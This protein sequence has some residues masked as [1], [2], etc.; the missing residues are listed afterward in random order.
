MGCGQ[1]WESTSFG[2]KSLRVH[3]DKRI[4]RGSMK[5]YKVIKET[6]GEKIA[7]GIR[8]RC[9][10]AEKKRD[11]VLQPEPFAMDHPDAAGEADRLGLQC[12]MCEGF[13]F[14]MGWGFCI[15]YIYI[16]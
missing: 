2:T 14:C 12:Q 16:Y 13:Q 8:Q 4:A 10:E 11:P 15:T 6:F 9:R 5:P 3:N 7:K 1:D